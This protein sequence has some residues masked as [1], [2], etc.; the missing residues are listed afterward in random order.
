MTDYNIDDGFADLTDDVVW[1]ELTKTG[2]ASAYL[3]D[4]RKT[5]QNTLAQIDISRTE[6]NLQL[7]LKTIT[8]QDKARRDLELLEKKRKALTFL[9]LVE[10]RQRK[11]HTANTKQLRS[12]IYTHRQRTLGDD[13]EP[14]EADTWLWQILDGISPKE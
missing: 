1:D 13:Y 4:A 7:E 11:V 8:K 3:E 10:K 6:N 9:N 2:E 14:T 5:V 12:A